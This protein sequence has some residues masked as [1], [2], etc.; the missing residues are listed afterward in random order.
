[1][2]ISFKKLGQVFELPKEPRAHLWV[3]LGSYQA[4]VRHD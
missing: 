3:R 2:S 1:M 4:A